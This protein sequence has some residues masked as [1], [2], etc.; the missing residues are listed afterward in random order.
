MH[1]RVCGSSESRW[2]RALHIS[3]SLRP[4]LGH[5]LPT[6]STSI[7]LQFLHTLSLE[8]GQLPYWPALEMTIGDMTARPS[9]LLCSRQM[10]SASHRLHG[11][12]VL[13]ATSGEVVAGSFNRRTG[14]VNSIALSPDGQRIASALHDH[15]IHVWDAATGE[16]VAG[17]FPGHTDSVRSV[18]FSLD[19]QRIATGSSDRTIRVWDAV[20]GEVVASPFTGHTSWI[21][22][23]AFSPDGER[24]ALAS[25]DRTILVWDAATEVV[26]GPFSFVNPVAFS[27][28]G[29]HVALTSNEHTIRACGMQQQER[30]CSGPIYFGHTSCVNSVAFSRLTG[31]ASHRASQDR[32]THVWGMPATGENT[33]GAFFINNG[34]TDLVECVAF[35]LQTGQH[36]T[37]HRPHLIA[38]FACMCQCG[39]PQ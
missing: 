9:P 30:D 5:A 31:S 38:Q 7:L 2:Q 8:R 26:A 14:W 3:I 27:P 19:C 13:D 1:S 16:V 35:S 39:M 29:R 17:P 34:Y 33:R 32:T 24:I 21:N 4:L 22:S 11:I 15:T 37:S 36:C 18:A 25:N 12:Q 28:D 10:G 23:V 20:T 6:F